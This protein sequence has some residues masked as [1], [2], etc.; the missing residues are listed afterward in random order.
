MVRRM[1]NRAR[2][3]RRYVIL[4]VVLFFV[5]HHVAMA[6]DPEPSARPSATAAITVVSA[7][8]AHNATHPTN[9]PRHHADAP[10]PESHP[11]LHCGTME[12]SLGPPITA[13]KAVVAGRSTGAEALV[14]ALVPNATGPIADPVL[15]STHSTRQALLQVFLH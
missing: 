12:A 2:L 13:A 14:L 6:A 8:S 1:V 4:L 11:S 7:A 3:V 10:D 5:E 15:V 9:L